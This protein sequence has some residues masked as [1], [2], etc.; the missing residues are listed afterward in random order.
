MISQLHWTQ[1]VAMLALIVL[2]CV[3]IWN[4]PA[5]R[6]FTLYMDLAI[7]LVVGFLLFFVPRG[8]GAPRAPRRAPP[9]DDTPTAPEPGDGAQ[10]EED[11]KNVDELLE[12]VDD[13]GHGDLHDRVERW[14][15]RTRE[16]I[17]EQGGSV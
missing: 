5:L 16:R 3:R 17:R 14:R 1:N 6:R 12:E 10:V 9:A 4:P 2:I 8:V 7:G 13:V 15:K 11:T